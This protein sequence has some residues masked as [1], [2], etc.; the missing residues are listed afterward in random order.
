MAPHN[1]RTMASLTYLLVAAYAGVGLG[2]PAASVTS[3]T[4]DTAAPPAPAAYT[5]PAGNP[6][7]GVTQWANNVYASEVLKLAVPNMT[8]ALATKASA[9]AKVPSFQWLDT[10]AKISLMTDTLTD[11]RAANK[12]GGTPNAGLF[13]VYDLPDRDCAAAASNGELSV[14]NG[15]VATYKTEY[16][17]AIRKVITTFSD[18]PVILVIEPDSVSLFFFGLWLSSRSRL[19]LTLF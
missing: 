9:V 5:F 4:A 14:A 7:A 15:G 13:V 10:R 1:T 3:P 6:F 16:I 11:I 17:D 2:A 12:A 18:V 8:A 19:R